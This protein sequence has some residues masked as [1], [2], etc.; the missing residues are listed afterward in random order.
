MINRLYTALKENERVTDA[1]RWYMVWGLVVRGILLLG[2][3]TLLALQGN[4]LLEWLLSWG[5][6][7]SSQEELAEITILSYIVI[8]SILIVGMVL[9]AIV[10]RR[11]GAFDVFTGRSDTADSGEA[12][13]PPE[14]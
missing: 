9:R 8:G 1:L 11:M 10:L 3:T 6:P 7:S 14:P 13:P 5:L 12:T 2:L 4:F